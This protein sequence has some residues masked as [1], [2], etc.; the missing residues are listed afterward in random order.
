MMCQ[1]ILT[2]CNYYTTQ[3]GDVDNGRDYA[4]VGEVVCGN[5]LYLSLN[6]E[7][8]LKVLYKEIK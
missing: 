2:N 6:F 3:S 4:W 8:K 1:C 7:V 5:S